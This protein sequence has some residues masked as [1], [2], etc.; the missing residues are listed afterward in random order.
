M[1]LWD[2]VKHATHTAVDWVEGKPDHKNDS[3]AQ[4]SKPTSDQQQQALLQMYQ[5]AANPQPQQPAPVGGIEDTLAIVNN[6]P[7]A[8]GKTQTLPSGTTIHNDGPVKLA[9]G[10][11]GDQ[12]TINV[13]GLDHSFTSATED[14]ID[15]L[16]G[17]LPS[18]ESLGL[19]P[20]QKITRES[21]YGTWTIYATPNY[22]GQVVQQ[23]IL[24]DSDGKILDDVDVYFQN[25]LLQKSIQAPMKIGGSNAHEL[26]P[27]HRYEVDFAPDGKPLQYWDNSTSYFNGDSRIPWSQEPDEGRAI[28]ESGLVFDVV[29]NALPFSGVVVKGT[30][31]I[32]GRIV[33]TIIKDGVE[34]TAIV[35]RDA[36]GDTVLQSY[37]PNGLA[38][39]PVVIKPGDVVD[40][41]AEAPPTGLAP[42][43]ANPSGLGGGSTP[44]PTG[45]NPGWG[46]T[47]IRPDDT[48]SID[49]DGSLPWGRG[50]NPPSLF[51][52]Y[53]PRPRGRANF[54]RRGGTHPNS[55]DP[56]ASQ[57]PDEIMRIDELLQ[58]GIPPAKIPG[59]I[60][61]ERS[62]AMPAE[63]ALT[64]AQIE[65]V[66]E[67][68]QNPEVETLVPNGMYLG[69]DGRLYYD[70]T[71]PGTVK[72]AVPTE[73]L[74]GKRNPAKT[75]GDGSGLPRPS[76]LNQQML[77]DLTRP[78][79]GAKVPLGMEEKNG[80][81]DWHGSGAKYDNPSGVNGFIGDALTRAR[82]RMKGYRILAEGERA[83]IPI[84][85]TDPQLYF[86]PDFIAWDPGTRQIILVESK[87][88][89][90]EYQPGQFLGYSE[91]AAGGKAL[92]IGGNQ[93]LVDALAK[94]RMKPEDL[95]DFDVSVETNRWTKDLAPTKDLLRQAAQDPGFGEMIRNTPPEWRNS[96]LTAYSELN[97]EAALRSLT[98]GDLNGWA[99]FQGRQ[100]ALDAA[101]TM[102]PS[103]QTLDTLLGV[104][105]RP[106]NVNPPLNNASQLIGASDV[107]PIGFVSNEIA[108][109]STLI[110]DAL[111]PSAQP[112]A[113]QKSVSQPL[114]LQ[115][116]IPESAGLA[117]ARRARGYAFGL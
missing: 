52:G 66:L 88:G 56:W 8:P 36:A 76:K 14:K 72:G 37:K 112:A 73:E 93:N 83:K 70:G 90:A 69:K 7:P 68:L 27:T 65:A 86:K 113:E 40:P 117:D 94:L 96:A 54:P 42:S 114:N 46:N 44:R 41:T 75:G 106:V 38:E 103:Q 16:R 12:K 25:G 63:R 102:N 91:Y 55:P 30:K 20:G 35:T 13:P 6:P 104:L 89:G 111:K 18:Q 28:D 85:G 61:A 59:I 43:K 58:Q 84:P 1:G 19:L 47:P 92:D 49:V 80:I 64:S 100:A 33:A 51:G 39:P 60:M 87:F 53:W 15:P 99:Y 57:K 24:K 48:G 4:P 21:P 115:I 22:N 109:I 97:A 95:K 116:S 78:D 105:D 74:P 81:N 10:L 2:K 45:P 32:A 110:T 79:G 26:E 67:H 34:E 9:N 5:Q 31:I 50:V 98:S 23:W 62:A 3:P 11:N 107:N 71:T 17:I 77:E 82:L 101:R 108:R 29:V